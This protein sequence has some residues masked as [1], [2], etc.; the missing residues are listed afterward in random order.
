MNKEII[1]KT[2]KAVK[3]NSPKRNFKQSIDLIIN[4]KNIDLKK[5]ENQINLFVTLQ[6]DTGKKVSVCA[7]VGPELKKSAE[8]ICD[9]VILADSF[10]RFKGKNELKKLARKHDFFISQANIM[11]KVATTFGR[12]LGPKGKMPNPKIGAVLPPNANVRPLCERLRKTVNLATKNEPTIKCM[13]GKEDQNSSQVTD[14]I[15]SVYN[16][17]VQRLPNDTQNIKSAMLKLTMGSSFALVDSRGK[18]TETKKAGDNKRP[19]QPRSNQEK[20]IE[21]KDNKAERSKTEQPKKKD[22][23]KAGKPK[24]G[25]ESEVKEKDS[26]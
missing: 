25:P 20:K 18:E 9:E 15:L 19:T 8:E 26:K 13:V 17:V 7:L 2:L 1:E 6:H 12:F 23:G 16:S 21:T 5:T 3:E 14:N 24:I 10:D 22:T 11:P 4:L